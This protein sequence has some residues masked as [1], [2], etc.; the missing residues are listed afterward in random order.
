M[1][2]GSSAT[3]NATNKQ[4][5]GN[6]TISELQAHTGILLTLRSIC[7]IGSVVTLQQQSC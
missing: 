1:E 2:L 3:L 5:G 6:L 7:L 4:T